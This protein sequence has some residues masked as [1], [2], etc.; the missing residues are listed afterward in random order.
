MLQRNGTTVLTA[1]TPVTGLAPI[2]DPGMPPLPLPCTNNN[3]ISLMDNLSGLSN[4]PN[5]F[6]K[7]GFITVSLFYK[8]TLSKA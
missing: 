5:S 1:A 4:F 6:D 8:P 2:D 7:P 3:I